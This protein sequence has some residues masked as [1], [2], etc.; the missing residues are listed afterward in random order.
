MV[1]HP[2]LYCDQVGKTEA[3]AVEAALKCLRLRPD[4]IIIRSVAQVPEG[5][6][7]R[8]EAKRS[9][10]QEALDILDA[11]L[12][13][14]HIDAKLFYID[15]F[16]RITINVTGPHLGLIIGKN[17]STLEALEALVSAIHN[18]NCTDYKPIIINP[19]G[20]RDNKRKALKVM[21]KRAVEAAGNGEKVGLP[22][23]GQRDRKLV[24]QI[25][26][27]FPGFRSRSVGEGKDR[28]VYVFL[29][30]D[31]DKLLEEEDPDD[32]QFLPPPD[33][34]RPSVSG[35]QASP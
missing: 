7:V 20:Y 16:D 33:A 13:G 2:M 30:T 35:P 8:V 34:L 1:V 25:L 9:R 6:K 17:G 5:V 12:R 21:V 29:E 11:F 3:E 19:G 23:M 31:Q 28:R 10:G 27:D 18:R 32:P 15:S 14:M 24:H 4:E 22:S 26:K